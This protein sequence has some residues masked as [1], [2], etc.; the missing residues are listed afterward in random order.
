MLVSRK[1]E[2][3]R[4]D[5]HGLNRETIETEWDEN[6]SWTIKI[7]ISPSLTTHTPS[8]QRPFHQQE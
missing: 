5:M 2:Y 4:H 6:E 1:S 3:G 8:M 7:T